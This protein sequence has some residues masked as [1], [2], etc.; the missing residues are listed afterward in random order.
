M[1]NDVR[2]L[3]RTMNN[4]IA[5]GGRGW[6]YHGTI[7]SQ[8]ASSR[9]PGPSGAHVGVSNTL[10]TPM[11]AFE[12]EYPMRVMRYELRRRSGGTGTHRGGDGVVRSVRVLEAAS[13]SLPTDRRRNGP[14]GAA[15]GEPGGVGRKLLDGKEPPPKSE[16]EFVSGGVATVGMPGGGGRGTP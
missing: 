5:I 11:E 13:L 10:D 2:K 4:L 6:T 9:G 16:R 15:G 14:K 7:G 12:L 3:V 1:H 8:G